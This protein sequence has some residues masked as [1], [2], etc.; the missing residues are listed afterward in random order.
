MTDTHSHLYME[1]FA[2]DEAAAMERALGA[3]VGLVM[4]PCVDLAS[5]GPMLRLHDLYPENTLAAIGLHPT[6]LGDDPQGTLDAMER[7][8]PGGGFSAI[9]EVGIDLYWDSTRREEQ[10]EAFA[11][12]LGWAQTHGLPLLI[13]CREGLDECLEVIKGAQGELP[14]MVFHS[15]TQGAEEVRRIR[16]VCDPWF[17]INGVVTFKNAPSLREALP[18]IGADRIVLETDAPYLAPVPHRGSRNESAYIPLILQQVSATLG[19]S[20]EEAERIT[21]RNACKLFGIE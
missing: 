9:G 10:M 14:R 20:E 8:V 7:M 18:V 12:Q 17:G 4:L 5:L 6:E 15:F 21:D 19:I 16:E 2:G 11:R 13:H 1:A 3:G